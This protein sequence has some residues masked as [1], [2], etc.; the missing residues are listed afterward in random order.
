MGGG[1]ILP[2]RVRKESRD[3]EAAERAAAF[4]QHLHVEF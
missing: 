3:P 4:G 1:D 2:I